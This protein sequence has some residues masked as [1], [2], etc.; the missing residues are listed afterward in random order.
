MKSPT[1]RN[2]PL[3]W[4][5]LDFLKTTALATGA[6]SLGVPTLLRGQNLNSKLNIAA[7]GVGGKG[8]SDVDCWRSWAG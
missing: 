5:R 8:A 2:Q 1:H 6:V 4:T 7:I 3:R